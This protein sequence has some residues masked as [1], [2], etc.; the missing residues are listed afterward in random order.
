MYQP[1]NTSVRFTAVVSAAS[2]DGGDE[3]SA[4]IAEGADKVGSVF[5]CSVSEA[6]TFMEL[7]YPCT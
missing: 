4:A 7:L 2:A 3:T 6:V 5:H 1:T